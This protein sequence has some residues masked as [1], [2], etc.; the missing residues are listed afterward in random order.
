MSLA[1][2]GEEDERDG[3]EAHGDHVEGGDACLLGVADGDGGGGGGEDDE[4]GGEV[5]LV[6]N[7]RFCCIVY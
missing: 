4:G 6:G 7:G 5:A 3:D 1:D 2:E